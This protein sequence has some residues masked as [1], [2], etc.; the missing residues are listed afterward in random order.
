M[1]VIQ[2]HGRTRRIGTGPLSRKR[3]LLRFSLQQHRR[4]LGSGSATLKK[5]ILRH[6]SSWILS[7][8]RVAPATDNDGYQGAPQSLLG[9]PDGNLGTSIQPNDALS[10]TAR[11][12]LVF[13]LLLKFDY[14][15]FEWRVAD[16]L[17]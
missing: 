11:A 8:S 17:W 3:H 2:V 10:S 15:H 14:Y 16:I 12:G 9:R 5:P 7:N 13:R 1:C 4:A 6:D